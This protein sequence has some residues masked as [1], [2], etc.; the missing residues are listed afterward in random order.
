MP[1]DVASCGTAAQLLFSAVCA[2]AVRSNPR[3]L[4]CLVQLTGE[5]LDP[6]TVDKQNVVL[7]TLT[8]VFNALEAN[9]VFYVNISNFMPDGRAEPGRAP[10]G[11]SLT[12][13]D[14]HEHET[15]PPAPT[16]RR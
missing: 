11:A 3:A 14:D 10:N 8:T 15:S 13:H 5:D 1:T 16:G 9:P 4:P 6:F 7:L 2:E 12:P